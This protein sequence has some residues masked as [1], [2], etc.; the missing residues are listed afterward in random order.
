[1]GAWDTNMVVH[2]SQPTRL[3]PGEDIISKVLNSS[4]NATD[5]GIIELYY[6]V[7]NG[8]ED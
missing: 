6:S 2:L 3:Q 5:T 8:Y 4:M 1:M 7:I